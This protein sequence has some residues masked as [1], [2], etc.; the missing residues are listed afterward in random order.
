MLARSS[1]A[2]TP[3]TTAT[4]IR[5]WPRRA[6]RS[7]RAHRSVA[8]H[9][10]QP[11]SPS[12]SRDAVRGARDGHDP[13]I[14]GHH[15]VEEVDHPVGQARDPGVVGD[16]QDR[17]ALGVRAAQQPEHVAGV[18]AVQVAGRLVGQQ[19]A[20][21]VGQ[22]AGQRDPLLLAAGQP[23]RR[24]ARLVGMPSSAS[25]SSRRFL[26]CRGVAPASSA[27]SS[28]LSA[29]VMLRQQV[30]ELEDEPDVPAA[31]DRPAGLDKPSTR[32]PRSQISPLVAGSSPP[33]TCSRV[34]LPEPDGPMIATNSP[35]ATS[36]STPRTRLHRDPVG[37]VHLDQLAG[38][39][40]GW[41]PPGSLGAD[42]LT[43]VP[44][45]IVPASRGP[46][47][48]AAWR[49]RSAAGRGCPPGRRRPAARSGQ[50]IRPRVMPALRVDQLHPVGQPRHRRQDQL[51]EEL[52][53]D[54]RPVARL[55]DPG[56]QCLT[57]RRGQLVDALV[58]PGGL[59]DVLAADQAVLLQALQRDVDLP[60]VR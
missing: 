15:P 48:G 3:A 38:P 35:S 57:A 11:L 46:P 59:L 30:E 26:A 9:Q 2:T 45:G 42:R 47:A 53:A 43:R 36:R 16:Q 19:Q 28:T 37:A 56:A 23:G 12:T 13:G 31:Q 1:A 25:S 60:D 10:P 4:V 55:V 29:T 20:G 6:R 5:A 24:G 8:S 33:S 21:L 14:V 50:R 51:D 49:P 34:D 54:P 52:I 44:P 40:Q 32:C 58:G 22:R 7:A 27:G 39:Q 41:A 17:L 18:G